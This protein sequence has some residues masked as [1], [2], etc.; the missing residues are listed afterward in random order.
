MYSILDLKLYG[1][2][3][4]LGNTVHVHHQSFVLFGALYRAEVKY[5]IE[6]LVTEEITGKSFTVTVTGRGSANERYK[7]HRRK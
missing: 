7:R 5:S 2:H 6:L 1:L 3:S 4:L